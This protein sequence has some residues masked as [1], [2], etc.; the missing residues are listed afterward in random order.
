MKMMKMLLLA[1]VVVGLSSIALADSAWTLSNSNSGNGTVTITT[2]GFS[3]MG[4]TN[5]VGANYTTYTFTAS[6]AETESF[7]WSYKT[8]DCCGSQWDPAGYV[9][10]G[11]YTQLSTNCSTAGACN[12]SGTL[13]INLNSG[14]VFGFYVYSVDSDNSGSGQISVTGTPEPA[15]LALL[16]TGL[17]GLV[18]LT[19]RKR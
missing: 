9:L 10:N 13:N 5:G 8:F 6:G 14:D 17:L 1:A 3:L 2:S 12:T 4:A 18:G 7:N 16:G 19:R 11:A 15:G